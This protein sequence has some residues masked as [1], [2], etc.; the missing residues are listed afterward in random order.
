MTTAR[1]PLRILKAQA[2]KIAANALRVLA[3]IENATK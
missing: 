1:S 3:E 2:D